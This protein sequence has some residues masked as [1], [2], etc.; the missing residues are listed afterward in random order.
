M[1]D[2]ILH[3]FPSNECE[4]LALLYVQNQDLSNVSPE[5]LWDKYQDAYEKIREHKKKNRNAKWNR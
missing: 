1:D 2:V 4:A 5:E 3:S